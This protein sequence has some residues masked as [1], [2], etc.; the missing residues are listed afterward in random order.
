[1]SLSAPTRSWLGA[2]VV[3]AV[4]ATSASLESRPVPASMAIRPAVAL[5]LSIDHPQYEQWLREGCGRNCR[6]LPGSLTD[7]VR[8]VLQ[9]TYGYVNWTSTAPARDTVEIKWIDY[10]EFSGSRLEFRLVTRD[11]VLQIPPVRVV[12]EL[13]PAVADHTNNGWNADAVY[14]AWAAGLDSVLP[15]PELGTRFF[16]HIPIEAG[17]KRPTPG[18]MEVN[19]R[20]ADIDLAKDI[21]PLFRVLAD[22]NDTLR[23]TRVNASV[24][25]EECDTTGDQQAYACSVRKLIYPSGPVVPPRFDSVLRFARIAPKHVFVTNYRSAL[26]RRTKST[27]EPPPE[28]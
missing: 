28:R 12:F 6:A 24:G 19:V 20:A 10:G 22:V 18:L 15:N 7:T 23:N 4:V 21:A 9:R 1:M 3:G 16:A 13:F 26:A 25:L 11:T 27:L 5:K 8:T 14:R 17:T 2:L